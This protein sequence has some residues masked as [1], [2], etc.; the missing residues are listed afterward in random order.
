[1]REAELAADRQD[2]SPTRRHGDLM[3][4]PL[5]QL[6]EH[7]RVAQKLL[8]SWR[9]RRSILVTDKKRSTQLLFQRPDAGTDRRLAQ[10]ELFG[11]AHKAACSDDLQKGSCEFDIQGVAPALYV[12][13][14]LH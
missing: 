12:A 4:G 7:W 1:M 10:V 13:L 9:Q 5:P 8:A 6:H 14:L 3:T 2:G 11:R